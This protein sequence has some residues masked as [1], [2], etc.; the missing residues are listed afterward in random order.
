MTPCM[1]F[2]RFLLNI[3]PGILS[4]YKAV[5]DTLYTGNAI[6]DATGIRKKKKDLGA[7]F[8]LLTSAIVAHRVFER[9]PKA[10]KLNLGLTVF[11]PFLK[12]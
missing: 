3:F 10:E 2:Q 4:L 12:S 11:F 8:N 6:W 9:H 7:P 1:G 5:S